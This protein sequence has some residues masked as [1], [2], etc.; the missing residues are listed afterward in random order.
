MKRIGRALI[1]FSLAAFLLLTTVSMAPATEAG[2]FYFG[3]FGGYVIPEDLEINDDSDWY[4]DD[5][6]GFE[7]DLDESWA[8]GV[9]FGYIIPPIKW[10]AVELE[11]TYLADQ[12]LDESAAGYMWSE[13]IRGDFSAHNLMGNL[14]FRCPAGKIHP[15]VGFGV[16]LSRATFKADATFVDGPDVYSASIDEDDTAVAGQFIAGVNFEI[17]PNVSAEIAYKYFYC[18]YEIEDEDV[19]AKNHLFTFG[20][21]FHF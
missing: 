4:D 1:V 16:G 6:G 9:K 20:I 15:Y 5:E 19:E 11:Y 12:D 17:T 8:V 3:V 2:P 18:E 21:N 10:L 14:L 13:K 7:V